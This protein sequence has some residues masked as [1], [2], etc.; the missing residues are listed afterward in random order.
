[1]STSTTEPPSRDPRRAR[2]F[3]V[4]ADDGDGIPLVYHHGTPGAALLFEPMVNA[5]RAVGLRLV[6]YS[7]PGYGD[8]PPQSGRSVADAAAD[9][10]AILD[11]LGADRFFT[12]GLSGGGPHALA[13]G[14]LLSDRCA[15]V[16]TIGGVAPYDAEGLDFL[17]GMGP[18]N[19]EEF[20]LAEQG[21]DALVPFLQAQADPL[22]RVDA[23]GIIE[24]LGGLLPQI[25]RE[26]LTGPVADW[27]VTSFHRAVA[28][29]ID[30][31]LDDDLAFT[32]DWGFALADISVPV[33]IWQ[34]GVDLMVPAAHGAWL[35]S[36]IP[37]ARPHLLP[38]HGHLS[39]AVVDLP[40]IVADLAT[41]R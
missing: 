21:R 33:A 19:I 32:R 26:A 15:A 24:A 41:L 16:A 13:C 35:A 18:E 7:R 38:D 36:H 25:D 40:R 5:A 28:H 11:D 30:G 12:I 39:L 31:W 27:M 10:A 6:T 1:V 23:A 9:T 34:G 37:T 17:A 14:A 2:H 29:G 20:G 8:T 3:E 22:G 4:L